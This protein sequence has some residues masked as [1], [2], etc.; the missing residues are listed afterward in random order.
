MF[1]PPRF[2]ASPASR[3]QPLFN[4]EEPVD[5]TTFRM[6]L[7]EVIY[8]RNSQRRVFQVRYQS[9]FW[10]QTARPDYSFQRTVM[11]LEIQGRARLRTAP[12][13]GTHAAPATLPYSQL[14]LGTAHR[15]CRSVTGPS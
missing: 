13:R 8:G 1:S 10:L 3:L 12:A 5:G 4:R 6:E 7:H 9:V 2:Y 11:F 15:D 14:Q